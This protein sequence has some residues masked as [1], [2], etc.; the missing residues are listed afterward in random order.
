MRW[1]LSRPKEVVL[2][3][4]LSLASLLLLTG[5]PSLQSGNG[6]PRAAFA[7]R[8]AVRELAFEQSELPDEASRLIEPGVRVGP[9]R[10]DDTRARALEVFRSGDHPSRPYGCGEGIISSVPSDRG[11]PGNMLTLIR[12]GKVFQID[13]VTTRFHT[14]EGITTYDSPEKVRQRYKDDLRAYVFDI[15]SMALGDRPVIFWVNAKRGI[16]FEFAY[17]REERK[18]YLYAI[19][20]FQPNGDWCPEGE[21]PDPKHWREIAPYSLE[22]TDGGK[23]TI[24][25]IPPR[26][27]SSSPPT[28]VPGISRP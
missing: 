14:A 1:L 10:L 19:S 2:S 5:Q 23:T 4:A 20:V 21:K 13:S 11:N 16:A 6:D 27:Q 8:F 3:W 15:T 18:R 12:D 9:L 24:W 22:P 17:Y 26:P 7:W 28:P 25:H